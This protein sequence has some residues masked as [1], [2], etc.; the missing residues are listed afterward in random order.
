MTKTAK[1]VAGRTS[2]LR[3]KI[4]G[5][6]ASLSAKLQEHQTNIFQ[7]HARKGIRSFSPS[8][9]AKLLGVAEGYLRTSAVE[10]EKK[11]SGGSERDFSPALAG[12]RRMYSVQDIAAM[13]AH[14]DK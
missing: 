1:A 9:A 13:R 3:S 7:P 5:H 4:A 2:P 11:A 12:G 10:L 8:E 14:L 6:S